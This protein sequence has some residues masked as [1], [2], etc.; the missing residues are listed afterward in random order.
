MQERTILEIVRHSG[1]LDPDWYRAT[2]PDVGLS[3][4]DPVV[5]FVRYGARLGRDPG[6]GF[7]TRAYVLGRFGPRDNG[8]NPLLH[9][10]EHGQREWVCAR[11]WPR[12]AAADISA[13][14][15]PDPAEVTLVAPHFDPDI[16]RASGVEIPAGQAIRCRPLTA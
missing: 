12:S 14:E 7:D 10:L 9:C 1:F 3:G 8:R 4:L 16:Y 15:N 11:A 5:H 6:P 13:T 2:Y